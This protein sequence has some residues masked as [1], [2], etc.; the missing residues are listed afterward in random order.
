MI[1]RAWFFHRDESWLCRVR[2]VLAKTLHRRS[3]LG[4]LTGGCWLRVLGRRWGRILPGRLLTKMLRRL[5]TL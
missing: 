2:V 1:R 5:G 3:I 4:I